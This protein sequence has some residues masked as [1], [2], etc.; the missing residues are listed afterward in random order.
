MGDPFSKFNVLGARAQ[1][2]EVTLDVERGIFLLKEV[3]HGFN[4]LLRDIDTVVRQ[5]KPRRAGRI[6]GGGSEIGNGTG[7]RSSRGVITAVVVVV[8]VV[9]VL[10]GT[11]AKLAT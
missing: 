1:R 9:V 5:R 7:C 10:V 3:L 6:L 11:A 4:L 8:I 2:Q